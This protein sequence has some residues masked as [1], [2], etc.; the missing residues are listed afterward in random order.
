[1]SNCLLGCLLWF[2]QPV[3]KQSPLPEWESLHPAY[4]EKP[5][6]VWSGR[7]GICCI[8]IY[9]LMLLHACIMLLYAC[10]ML[11]LCCCMLVLCC[12]MLVL[13]LYYAAACL[14]YAAT[15]C[16]MLVLCCC[17]LVLCCC[18]LVLCCCMLAYAC[19]LFVTHT[20]IF[21]PLLRGVWHSRAQLGT[22][23]EE[24]V[25]ANIDPPLHA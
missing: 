7:C 9:M 2:M 6:N 13:C 12:C 21:S 24:V 8:M 3:L 18:M 1:M 14:Y 10:I 4:F 11:V 5:Y 16:C 22:S 17:M 23:Y 20:D 25:L 19:S 15:C